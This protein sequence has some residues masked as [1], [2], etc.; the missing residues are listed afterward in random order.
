MKRLLLA[1]LLFAAPLAAQETIDVTAT[2][3]KSPYSAAERSVPA[4]LSPA[5][6]EAYAR[7][8]R[9]IEKG[10]ITAA[11]AELSAMP[12]GLLHPSAGAQILRRHR[13]VRIGQAAQ[14]MHPGG[15]GASLPCTR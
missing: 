13:L 4:Q 1:T 9:A 6:R 2:P 14:C 5:Q 10:Q 8:F 11:S 3:L 12:R 7:I 15:H